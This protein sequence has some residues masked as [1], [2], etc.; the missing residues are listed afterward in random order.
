MKKFPKIYP[1][2]IT[3]A[4]VFLLTSLSLAGEHRVIR[5]TMPDYVAIMP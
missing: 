2:L 5:V 3:L 4:F 1:F